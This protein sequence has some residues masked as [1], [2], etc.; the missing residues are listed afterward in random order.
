[1]SSTWLIKNGRLSVMDQKQLCYDALDDALHKRIETRLIVKYPDVHPED[2][3]KLAQIHKTVSHIFYGTSTTPSFRHET[4]VLTLHTA[5]RSPPSAAV[6]TEDLNSFMEL[7]TKT[8]E[9]V[10]GNAPT[11]GPTSLATAAPQST[12]TMGNC[13]FATNPAI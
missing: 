5:L 2:G 4:V 13:H 9:Y 6:K 8:L 11:S 12:T 3:Y 1:M 7:F 10:A